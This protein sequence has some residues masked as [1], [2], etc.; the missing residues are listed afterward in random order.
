MQNTH[1]IIIQSRIIT[2]ARYDYSVQEQ[3]IV[4]LIIDLLQQYT[5][6]KDL[7]TKYTLAETLFGDYDF[8][9]P[10]TSFMKENEQNHSL[11]IQS[12]KNLNAKLIEI[13][14]TKN[15]LSFNL[16]E[17]PAFNKEDG[18]V[19][20]RIHPLLADAFLDFS[21]GYSKY[22]LE[23]IK[24]FKS[25]FAMRFYMLFSKQTAAINYGVDT[26][27]L[28]FGLENKYVGRNSDF[29][30]KVIKSAKKE[31]DRI[32]PISFNYKKYPE[33]G[34]IKG[35]TFYPYK[36]GIR[37]PVMEND[38][39]NQVSI[40]WDL[41]II[42]INYLKENFNF[43]DSEIKNNMTL[44]KTCQTK[45]G[46]FAMVLSNIK[47]MANNSNPANRQGYL[48]KALKMQL[49]QLEEKPKKKK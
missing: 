44:L 37:D 15:W 18:T 11:V 8:K 22:S 1:S 43:I 35:Y 34:K 32:C 42:F 14:D 39:K 28:M 4:F 23:V 16:I 26:L 38:L 36:T 5:Q 46:D 9:L 45:L 19:S 17:R 20:F 40:H 6:G 49:E 24:E 29:E 27:K 48:I 31:L 33:K 47:A 7:K 10:L 41:D 30:N 21:K 2:A 13:E 12:L 3:R 25:I